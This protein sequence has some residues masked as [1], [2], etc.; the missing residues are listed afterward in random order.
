MINMGSTMDYFAHTDV[1]CD[2]VGRTKRDG[3]PSHEVVKIQCLPCWLLRTILHKVGHG[4]PRGP[5][6]E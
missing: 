4:I 2:E 5:F 3:G 6:Y 1:A